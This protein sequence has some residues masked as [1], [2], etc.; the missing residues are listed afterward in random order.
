M[1]LVVLTRHT[2][3]VD[4]RSKHLNNMGRIAVTCAIPV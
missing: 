1:D 4:A 3:A 2:G